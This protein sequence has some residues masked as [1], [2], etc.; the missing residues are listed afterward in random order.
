M[1]RN[2]WTPGFD[3]E[4]LPVNLSVKQDASSLMSCDQ[5]KH[6]DGCDA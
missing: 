2:D 3:D 4:N 5:V 6:M 1:D